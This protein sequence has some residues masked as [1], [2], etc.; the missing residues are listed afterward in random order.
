MLH[1][2]NLDFSFSG[3]KTAV[4][5]IVDAHP[6]LELDEKTSLAREFEDSVADVLVDKTMRAI[7]RFGANTIVVGGGVSA[8]TYIRDRLA[9][10]LEDEGDP[11]KLLIPPPDLATDNALMIALAGYFHAVK[12]DFA[13][14]EKLVANGNLKLC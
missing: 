3:L 1:E 14:P 9:K 5:K 2:D 7:D 11:A 13:D 6:N 10:A 12:K 8:N 4:R